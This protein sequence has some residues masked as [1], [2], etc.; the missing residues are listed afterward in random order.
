MEK[1]K[2]G[3]WRE[4]PGFPGLWAAC[5]LGRMARCE[6][7][8]GVDDRPRLSG[9]LVAV[10]TIGLTAVLMAARLGWVEPWLKAPGTRV[11][12]R[13]VAEVNPEGLAALPFAGLLALGCAVLIGLAVANRHRWRAVLRPNRG[14]VI[15]AL[16]LGFVT[17]VAVYSWGPW[18]IGGMWLMLG[19]PALQE[20]MA[21][22]F[23]FGLMVLTAAAAL[24][25]PFACLIVSGIHGRLMRVAVFAL[26]F[27]AAY[28]AF[29][30]AVG[31]GPRF[32]L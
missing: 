22:G 20:G 23:F 21:S 2:P 10:L 7:G 32:M 27:W 9:R 5:G 19:L 15:G 14:R 30:L 26:M 3:K 18:I 25:Y 13:L 4:G 16:A 24:W 1:E 8:I 12:G 31:A 17:P 6:L 29:I 28:S 11:N